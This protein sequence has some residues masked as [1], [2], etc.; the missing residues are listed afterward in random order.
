MSTFD[1][2]LKQP[3]PR[4]GR[5]KVRTWS[6]SKLYSTLVVFLTEF[7]K[8]LILGGKSVGDKKYKI[9]QYAKSLNTLWTLGSAM[10]EV[11]NFIGNLKAGMNLLNVLWNCISVLLWSQVQGAIIAISS[12]SLPFRHFCWVVILSRK[13]SSFIYGCSQIHCIWVSK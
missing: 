11:V 10:R 13:A 5:T 1:N 6:G 7:S 2:C 3:G 9:T 8:K 4:S 12:G